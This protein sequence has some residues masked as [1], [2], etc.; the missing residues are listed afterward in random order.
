MNLLVKSD[1]FTEL[2]VD[3][4]LNLSIDIYLKV[5]RDCQ[6][7]E[8]KFIPRLDLDKFLQTSDL[9]L[10]ILSFKGKKVE[11]GPAIGLTS[12]TKLRSKSTPTCVL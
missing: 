8:N 7:D 11:L 10:Y 5:Q 6:N 3:L 1:G 12:L 4:D 2:D 9:I